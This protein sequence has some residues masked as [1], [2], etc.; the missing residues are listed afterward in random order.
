MSVANF[1]LILQVGRD[2]R[3][4]MHE[5]YN[6]FKDGGNPEKELDEYDSFYNSNLENTGYSSIYT[7]RNGQKLDGWYPMSYQIESMV[8]SESFSK[9]NMGSSS[10]VQYEVQPGLI[11]Y[12]ATMDELS[13]ITGNNTSPTA[14][15][16]MNKSISSRRTVSKIHN[17]SNLVRGQWTLE[18]DR[19][20]AK[21]VEKHGLRK[22]SHIAKNLQGRV[23]K[24]C[25]ERW[26]NHLRPNIKKDTWSE[27]EDRTLIQ[28]HREVG[29]KWAEIAKKLP[30]RTENS[31]KNHWNATKR[32]F[33]LRGG[34][35]QVSSRHRK[36][37]S[38]LENYIKSL[39]LQMAPS[40]RRKNAHNTNSIANPTKTL[41]SLKDEHEV[42]HEVWNYEDECLVPSCD[43]GDLSELLEEP[44]IGTENHTC[45]EEDVGFLFNQ[46]GFGVDEENERLDIMEAMK[47]WDEMPTAFMDECEVENGGL[48]KKE[49]DLV[50]M[51][52]TQHSEKLS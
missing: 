47:G 8:T 51:I 48:M 36:S 16:T 42:G 2:P 40:R 33:A 46:L 39:N 49:M 44:G 52:T 21:L 41:L 29:N 37:N 6:L 30:G 23:G 13:C 38:L 15:V 45:E 50:E 18:E 35:C 31:I 3:P 10:M 34:G 20:L 12:K 24:Q 17:K 28:I 9:I 5:A 43:F 27:E 7:Q 22:W 19:M 4:V 11:S 26:H 25:R 14:A 1:C 32:R